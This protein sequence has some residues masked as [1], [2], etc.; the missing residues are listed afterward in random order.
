MARNAAQIGLLEQ[1]SKDEHLFW[2]LPPI[3]NICAPS[4]A[5]RL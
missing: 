5:C 4:L 1:H 2:L 3:R